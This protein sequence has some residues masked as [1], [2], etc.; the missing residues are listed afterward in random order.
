M[1]GT[2]QEMTIFIR[3]WLYTFNIFGDFKVLIGAVAQYDQKQMKYRESDEEYR[4]VSESIPGLENASVGDVYRI[5]AK[6]VRDPQYGY[7]RRIISAK[8]EESAAIH[9][10][11]EFL[12]RSGEKSLTP[13][14]R[15]LLIGIHGEK[16]FDAI[17]AD[18]S[19]LDIIKASPDIKHR[20]YRVIADGRAFSAILAFLAKREWDCRWALPLYNAFQGK[21][22]LKLRTNPYWL[23]EQELSGFRA[24]DRVFLED[25]GAV[26][27]PL[28]CRNAVLAALFREAKAGGSFISRDELREK[29]APLLWD[30]SPNTQASNCVISEKDISNALDWLEDSGQ[31]HIDR[32]SGKKDIYPVPL[33]H[34][35]VRV[36]NGMAALCRA[37]KRVSCPAHK[38]DAFL[39]E[40]RTSGNQQLT[41]AQCEAVKQMLT[42]PVSVITGG[43]GTGKTFLVE[44]AIAALHKL[45]PQAVVQCCAPTGKAADHMPAEAFTIARL[46]RSEKWKRV[47]RTGSGEP[48]IVFV[49]EVSMVDIG[50]FVELLDMVPAGARLVLIGDQNQL[51]S[52]QPG[53]VLR[54][55]IDSGVIR[56]VQLREVFRQDENSAI[57]SNAEKTIKTTADQDIHLDKTGKGFAFN[58]QV[59]NPYRLPYAVI[60]AIEITLKTGIPLKEIKVIVRQQ[61]GEQGSRNFNHIL[62]DHFNT[63]KDGNRLYCG[64]KEF[65][66][67]DPVIHIKNNYDKNVFNGEVG[68]VIE[69]QRTREWAL[70]VQYPS[71]TVRYSE[72]DLAEL[73]LAYA[74][75]AHKCQGSEY[76]AVILPVAGRGITRRWL[77]TAETRGRRYVLL[78]GTEDALTAEMRGETTDERASHLALRLQ[79]LLPPVLPETEQLSMFPPVEN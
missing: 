15:E 68:T 18:P 7:Q 8:R 5:R 49:D 75:T 6:E 23:W 45:C 62:Q 70:T 34:A 25:G 60:R 72:A 44:A 65:R 3:K 48:D 27:A 17:S 11:K 2:E 53:Q 30:T 54:D 77:Y 52:I 50:L 1:S 39:A 42:A 73:E 64:S 13:K 19:L 51:P 41:A 26:D 36:A 46:S 32:I 33:Y 12:A 61:Q 22:I 69:I 29:I 58:K 14:R 78:I 21:A 10:T 40:Y 59:S 67:N 71:K 20:I 31:I 55:L 76:E 66:L 79:K 24:A 74:L 56:T 63:Q 35:E 4:F 43:P 16:I 28:R 38:L 57:L 37:K 47:N 9:I